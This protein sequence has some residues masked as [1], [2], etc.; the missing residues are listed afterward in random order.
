MRNT[1]NQ[2]TD[3]ELQFKKLPYKILLGTV[4]LALFLLPLFG[5]ISDRHR[6]RFG[7]RTPF[8]VI[9]TLIAAASFA[10]PAR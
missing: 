3:K 2:K 6:G 1:G 4:I 8:I 7:R 9:G 10:S 5:A